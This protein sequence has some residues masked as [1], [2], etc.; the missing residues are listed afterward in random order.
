MGKEKSVRFSSY[1][2]IVDQFE[3]EWRIVHEK[4]KSQFKR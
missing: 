2:D 3:R 1:E 4:A